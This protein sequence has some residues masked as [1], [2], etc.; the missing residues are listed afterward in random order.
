MQNPHVELAGDTLQISCPYDPAI[1]QTIRSLGKAR[2]DPDAKKWLLQYSQV[3]L[4]GVKKMFPTL[5]FG[6]SIK[7]SLANEAV[8][9]ADVAEKKYLP[10]AKD[11][12][13]TDFEF[14]TEPFIHQKVTFNFARSLDCSAIFL[15][16]G[17]GKSKCAID[18]ATWRFRKKQIYRVLIL[19]PNSVTGQWIEEIRIHGH[20]DFKNAWRLEGATVKKTK[21][22]KAIMESDEPG[23]IV[24][25]YESMLGLFE[26]LVQANATNNLFQQIICDESSRIKHAQSKR[27]KLTWRLGKTVKYR[28]IMTGTP[29]TQDGSDIFSQ[30]RFLNDKIFGT[31][32]TAFRA[33]YLLLGGFENRQIVGYRNF[34]EFLKKVYSAA[35]R[36]T[37]DRCL[38][39][40]AK[41][42]QRRIVRLDED[43]SKLYCDFERECVAQF[44]GA[45]ISAPLVMTKMMK[46]SQVLG[47]F[48]YSTGPDGKRIATHVLAKN[49]KLDDLEEFIEEIDGKKLIIWVRFRQEIVFIHALLTRLGIEYTTISGSVPADE[50]AA[51]V[52]S[53]QEDPTVQV[54]VGQVQTAGL[55]I[56]LTAAE[57][58]YY[59]SNGYALEERLQSEDRCHR[60]GLKHSVVYVDCLVETA[61]GKRTI[62]HDVIDILTGKSKFAN[63]VS[64]ALMR[65]MLNRAEAEPKK[66]TANMLKNP[67]FLKKHFKQDDAMIDE[68]ELF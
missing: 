39:L 30:Y 29:I 44:D 57:Y 18:L 41:I 10:K 31:Y 21:Q 27:S 45:T 6:P 35:I 37:K 60:I 24:T 62:D 23:F 33:Q 34:P 53:F 13:I 5:A 19:A 11:V 49:P 1:I 67:A 56:T 12:V 42:Y 7:E 17:L 3:A 14:K 38:D 15:E 68:G 48:C 54:F 25:N 28:N 50:R 22:L 32:V 63:E 2:W 26:Y 66:P 58:V 20:D 36:F 52:K 8:S 4:E 65:A 59:Y 46:L 43:V 47:G 9:Q 40:P 55:G 64:L 61:N 51:A 16:Q